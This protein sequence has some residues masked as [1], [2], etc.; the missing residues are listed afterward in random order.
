MK[1]NTKQPSYSRK[2]TFTLIELLVVIAIIAILAGMLL[3]ALNR[4]RA[5]AISSACLSNLKQTYMRINNYADDH[6][7]MTPRPWDKVA[8]PSGHYPWPQFLTVKGY[9]SAKRRYD[10]VKEFQ[11]PHPQLTKATQNFYGI[12][13]R[14]QS[15][16]SINL[17]ANVPLWGRNGTYRWQS[18]GEMVLLSDTLWRQGALDISLRHGHSRMDDSN[19]GGAGMALPH[20]RHNNLINVA[21]GDGHAGSCR[22]ANFGDSLRLPGRWTYYVGFLQVLGLYP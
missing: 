8:D 7:G 4:A 13:I 3:P 2:S 15:C 5:T 17:H 21:Y 11:C 18:H 19:Y 9:T 12:R 22:V 20:F 16:Q 14:E 6:Q 10:G 1:T